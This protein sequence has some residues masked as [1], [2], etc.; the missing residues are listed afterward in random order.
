MVRID[1]NNRLKTALMYDDPGCPCLGSTAIMTRDYPVIF[2]TLYLFA[3]LGLVLK[4]ISDIAY[5]L[6]NPR[7]T[8]EAG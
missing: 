7:I 5:S 2:G 3:L 1:E 8:F 4:L 6:V